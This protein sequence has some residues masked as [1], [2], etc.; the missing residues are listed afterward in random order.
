MTWLWEWA[1]EKLRKLMWEVS[2][3]SP[4]YGHS[5]FSIETCQIKFVCLCNLINEPAVMW[6]R[7]KTK[8][9]SERNIRAGAI[10]GTLSFSLA[11]LE[12]KIKAITWILTLECKNPALK[13]ELCYC[14][15]VFL[16]PV[17]LY[18]L[19]V[20]FSAQYKEAP[21]AQSHPHTHP[22]WLLCPGHCCPSHHLQQESVPWLWA[23]R[24]LYQ[25]DLFL[26]ILHSNFIMTV[27][28][29]H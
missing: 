14:G 23:T 27:M 13:S 3:V 2:V 12:N 5:V 10:L 8:T 11:G 28:W 25:F 6:S 29:S 7:K 24:G 15:C 26:C 16:S 22:D 18:V 1:L 21:G 9:V 19:R 17:S 4:V 20:C